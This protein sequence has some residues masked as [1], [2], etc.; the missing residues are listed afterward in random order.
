M[1]KQQRKLILES[2][3]EFYLT[4]ES[5]IKAATIPAPPT[6]KRPTT[7]R[8]THMNDYGRVD[9]DVFVRI[10]DPKAPLDGGDFDTVSDWQNVSLVED[11]LWSDADGDWVSSQESDGDTSK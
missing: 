4:G 10:G 6:S 5:V 1:P 9:S 8:V 2:K 11:L 7:V 3:T